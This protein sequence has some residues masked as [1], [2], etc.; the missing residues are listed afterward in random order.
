M[1]T[2]LKFVIECTGSMMVPRENITFSKHWSWQFGDNT[3][4]GLS[5]GHRKL[6]K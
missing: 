2:I 1:G 3:Q 4:C 5:R 6:S